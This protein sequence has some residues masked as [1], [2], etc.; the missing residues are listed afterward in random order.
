MCDRK[1]AVDNAQSKPGSGCGDPKKPCSQ[2]PTKVEFKED[3]TN[4][5]FDDYT[6]PSVPWKSVEKGKS[7]TVKAVITPKGLASSVLFVSV[8]AAKVTVSPATA[9]SDEQIVTVQGIDLGTSEVQATCS[10]STL[11]KMN[12]KTYVKKTKTVAVRLVHEKNYRSIDVSD[13]DITAFLEKVYRQAVFEFRL[14]RL[15]EMTVEFDKNKDGKFDDNTWMSD[16]MKIIRDACKDDSYD[17]NIFLVDNP[18]YGGTGFM[19]FNQRY[20][21]IN[22]ANS[23]NP[24]QT[25]AHELG[26]GAFGLSHTPN[27]D[28]VN[29]MHETAEATKGGATKWRLR[30]DQWDKI[31]P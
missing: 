20:G 15:P 14:T 25:I 7:D 24:A 21:F 26:H 23:N 3:G 9:S 16:E 10:G 31:N 13:A 29:V 11:G 28:A 19:D 30:K 5:G 22:P 27:A 1:K 4:Y 17:H 18:T 6:N 12:V 2:C 8:D